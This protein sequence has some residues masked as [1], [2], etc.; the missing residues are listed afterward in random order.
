MDFMATLPGQ[1][2]YSTALVVCIGFGP[3]D[4]TLD[5]AS[6]ARLFDGETELSSVA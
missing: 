6:D 1:L 3:K 5:S 2:F 4:K